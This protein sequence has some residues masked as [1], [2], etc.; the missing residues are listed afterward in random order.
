MKTKGNNNL[1]SHSSFSQRI[2]YDSQ[3]F[4][5]FSYK[6]EQIDLRN[7]HLFGKVDTKGR[8]II[9]AR[10][11]Y[12]QDSGLL[13]SVDNSGEHFMLAPF[14][15]PFIELRQRFSHL[16]DRRRISED[17]SFIGLEPRKSVSFLEE[18]YSNHLSEIF[19]G[20]YDFF[21]KSSEKDKV[22]DFISFV[23]FFEKFVAEKCPHTIF[24]LKN[25][26]MS[27]FCNPLC[28]GMMIELATEDASNDEQ[29][30]DKFFNDPNYSI[31][32]EEAAYYG[33]IVDK[34]MPWR[35]VVNPNSSYMKESMKEHGFSSLQDLF[36]KAYVTSPDLVC[37][38]MYLK[39]LGRIYGNLIIKNPQYMV[40]DYSR[41]SS[42]VSIKTR[43][44]VVFKNP[45]DIMRKMGDEL[46]LKVYLSLRVREKNLDF[47]QQKFDSVIKKSLAL[48]K[49]VDLMSSLV[50][51]DNESSEGSTSG[52]KPSFRI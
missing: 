6:V 12:L 32:V 2:L 43:E 17:S 44:K 41:G 27:R 51:I 25:Y 14:A 5:G 18:E 3:S 19:D 45:A 9:L 8:Q 46:S 35:L 34:H 42:S 36:S 23:Y 49:Q 16:F 48:K 37:Y 21:K 30:Y 10:K 22:V 15:K 33:F 20:F 52:L 28:S 47:N 1:G 39:M 40:L 24:T 26:A 31:F 11:K 29:K 7:L 13:V 4:S 50:Y 38:E